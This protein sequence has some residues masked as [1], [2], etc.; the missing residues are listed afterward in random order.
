ME[1]FL[2]NIICGLPCSTSSFCIDRV[3]TELTGT[4]YINIWI[5]PLVLASTL[6]LHEKVNCS[7]KKSVA[8]LRENQPINVTSIL[9]HMF[10]TT[11]NV[12][13]SNWEVE[14]SKAALL[15]MGMDPLKLF[16][17]SLIL[18]ISSFGASSDP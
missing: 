9:Y 17:W 3:R 11:Y 16:P 10:S 12:V 14:L 5:L 15:F 4:K 7:K 2:H 18:I 13:T 8:L 6:D 1:K